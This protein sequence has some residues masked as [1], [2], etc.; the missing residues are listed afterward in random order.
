MAGRLAVASCAHTKEGAPPE[1]LLPCARI[2]SVR[3]KGS[4]S[5]ATRLREC[6]NT[7]SGCA[8]SSA[9][10]LYRR[11]KHRAGASGPCLA[12][13]QVAW[14]LIDLAATP[15]TAGPRRDGYGV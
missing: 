6:G 13:E 8:L 3:F 14:A 2:T 7:P 12:L 10:A 5:A 4:F 1:S 11:K 9:F 15:R